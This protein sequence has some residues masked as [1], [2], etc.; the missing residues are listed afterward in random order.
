MYPED[1]QAATSAFAA[2]MGYFGQMTNSISFL[3]SLFGTKSIIEKLGFSKALLSFPTLLL[4]CTVVLWFMPNIW[5]VFVVMMIIKGMSYALNNPTKEIL[6]QSTSSSIKFK[7]KS[8]IDTFGQ[9][10]AKAGGSLITNAC[11]TNLNDLN[12]YGTLTGVILSVFLLWVSKKMGVEF[13]T[14]QTEGRKIGEEDEEELQKEMDLLAKE[15][16][17]VTAKILKSGDGIS[18]DDEGLSTSCVE[19]ADDKN[20]MSV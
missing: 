6:Y 9:R 16:G 14:L 10:G 7:C 1:P 20:S 4:V 2:F 8:W 18:E 12:N 3:F 19:D 17:E 13:E 15:Q 5:V 11:A